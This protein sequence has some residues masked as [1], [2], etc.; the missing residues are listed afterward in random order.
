MKMID[1]SPLRKLTVDKSTRTN[2]YARF[3]IEPFERGYGHTIGNAIRRVIL[4]SIEGAAITSVRIKGVIHEYSTIEGIKEDVIGIILNLKKVRVKLFSEGPEILK[5]SVKSKGEVTAADITGN[6]NVEI[7]NPE[8]HIA[9]LNPGASLEM[10]MEVN[11]GY[12]YATSEENERKGVPVGTIFIDSLFSPIVKVNYEVENT[13][14]EQFTD[15]EKI[16]L[17][18]WT[19]GTVDPSD[20]VAYAAKTLRDILG[21]FIGKEKEEKKEEKAEEGR[22]VSE[23]VDEKRKELLEQSVDILGL[24]TRPKNCLAKS[25]IKKLKDLISKTEDEI[26]QI[27]NM[28]KGS[29][30]EIKNKLEEL[31]LTLKSSEKVEFSNTV[32]IGRVE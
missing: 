25:G 2:S 21:V 1:L 32:E 31:G 12:G 26:L 28:G 10:E 20:A 13:R 30:E 27:E 3:I 4:S 14:V 17:D 6:P 29:L 16:I 9:T 15:F 19:D 23:L 24:S 5:L 18:V 22:D 8:Q 7:V 11:K